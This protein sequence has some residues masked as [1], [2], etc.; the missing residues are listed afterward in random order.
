MKCFSGRGFGAGV[1]PGLQIRWGGLITRLVG[2]IP[3]LSRHFKPG[4]CR[5]CRR[6]F[7]FGFFCFP[8]WV[9]SRIF[10]IKSPL[11][12]QTVLYRLKLSAFTILYR[13]YLY[14][15]GQEL[16]MLECLKC[17]GLIPRGRCRNFFCNAAYGLF[18]SLSSRSL[19]QYPSQYFMIFFFVPPFSLFS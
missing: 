9:C 7:F 1:R 13:R 17:V 10:L 5:N 19:I 18:S 16:T 15:K 2:S 14:I 4:T 3:A 6:V 11:K 12:S 8:I